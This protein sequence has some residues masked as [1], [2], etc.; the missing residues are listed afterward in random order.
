MHENRKQVENNTLLL[1]YQR[2]ITKVISQFT[3]P[4]IFHWKFYYMPDS[5]MNCLCK[6]KPM[7]NARFAVFYLGL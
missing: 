5:T 1:T 7:T 3:N 4:G 6:N 2:S